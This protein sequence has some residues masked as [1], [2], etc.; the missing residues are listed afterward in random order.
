M[1]LRVQLLGP[2][3]IARD[4]E[5]IRLG[6]RKPW[7]LLTYLLL[8]DRPP[9]RRDVAARLHPEANDPLAALRWL[10]HQVRRAVEPEV[11]IDERGG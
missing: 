6:G 10:L 5:P 1:T 7:G 3:S 2:P 11:R 8:E 9:T 4:A